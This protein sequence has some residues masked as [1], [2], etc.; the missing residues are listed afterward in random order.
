MVR[1]LQ[2]GISG[3]AIWPE[4]ETKITFGGHELIL[5]PATRDTE[6][7]VHIALKGI[8]DIEGLTV[9]N[10]FL[11]ILTWCDGQGMETLYNW[12][13]NPIPVSVP[14]RSRFV[15]SSIAF[16]FYRDIE[17]DPKA[18]LA[19]ALYREART[20]SSIPFEFLSY[21]K[22]L[23]IFWQ[24]KFQNHKNELI[25]GLREAL[26]GLRY[27]EAVKRI[28]ALNKQH[29]DVAAYLYES[30]RCA[31]A[32]AHSDPIVDPDNIS[33]LRRLS[34]DMWI[35][36]AVAEFLIENKLHVSRSII[37]SYG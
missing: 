12:S 26:S 11:S 15:G 7:S 19:L 20:I 34:D 14:K 2:V 30:G 17:D 4:K 36:K 27:D 31:V 33:D 10:R 24:D 16:P 1:Y 21:F 3:E 28:K 37:G 5:R 25:E 23:N 18:R 6:Q 29:G 8:T 35:I 32:H 22:I 13:G 9:I